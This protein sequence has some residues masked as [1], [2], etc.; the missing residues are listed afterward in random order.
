MT[1]LGDEMTRYASF[2]ASEF[3]SFL[4]APIGEERN[5]MLLS[6]LSALARL[7]VDPWQEAA[8]L[9]LLPEAT[10]TETLAALIMALPDEPSMHRDPATIAARLVPLLP[11]RAN[12][13][14]PRETLHGFG[15][16]PKFR[17]ALSMVLINVILM[18]VLLGAECVA[19]S[20]R[21]LPPVVAKN[22]AHVSDTV[23]PQVKT[24]RS[25]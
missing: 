17:Y 16:S 8:K 6:V 2:L 25:H 21:P 12:A 11:R 19:A 15:A 14:P 24:P 4:F 1:R 20:H 18:A 22:P 13:P 5:G 7:D 23:S 3:D 9:A 10:A